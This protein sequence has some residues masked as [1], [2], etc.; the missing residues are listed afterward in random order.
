MKEKDL[1]VKLTKEITDL[2]RISEK[3][4]E[5]RFSTSKY[6][7]SWMDSLFKE[8]Q[9]T[10]IRVELLMELLNDFNPTK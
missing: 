5:Q 8:Y 9:T 3:Q 6:E 10:I 2:R 4:F 7:D 1:L